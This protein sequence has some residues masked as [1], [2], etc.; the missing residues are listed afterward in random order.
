MGIKRNTVHSHT[1]PQTCQNHLSRIHLLTDIKQQK[2]KLYV[3]F[4]PKRLSSFAY[5]LM[6]CIF[7]LIHQSQRQKP[8]ST[9][10]LMGLGIFFPSL[11]SPSG[12]SLGC[13]VNVISFHMAFQRA[14]VTALSSSAFAQP[15]F[16]TFP[17]LQLLLCMSGHEGRQGEEKGSL[18]CIIYPGL[19]CET[20]TTHTHTHTNFFSFFLPISQQC[21]RSVTQN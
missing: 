5:S 21:L 10:R 20:L 13:D 6:M 17:S 15:S 18:E 4:P 3:F 9:G 2:N 19:P 14:N 12:T 1:H 7:F 11:Q 8:Y 16:S